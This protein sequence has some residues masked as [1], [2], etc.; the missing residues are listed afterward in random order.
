MK[1]KPGKLYLI[2]TPIGASPDFPLVCFNSSILHG[3]HVF[4]VEAEKSARKFLKQCA[5]PHPFEHQV[6]LELNEHTHDTEAGAFLSYVL[7]GRD[8][9][10]MSEAG[11]P[12]IA[13]PGAKAVR[14]A[15]THGIEVIPLPG[16]S[17]VFLALMASGGNGQQF[18]FHGYLPIAKHSRQ[19][20][21]RDIEHLAGKTGA[22][23]IF[24]ETP[25]R[26]ISLI[27]QILHTCRPDTMLCIACD[28][29]GPQQ[30]IITDTVAGWKVR[31]AGEF[32][33]IPAVFIMFR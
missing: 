14:L 33:K 24:M 18:T 13:D 1:Q 15:H 2:P 8:A 10:L 20:K 28:L 16:P 6:F 17:S 27:E 7:E 32:R 29:L 22:S 25:Y 12:C 9:G 21:L 5:Y 26:N 4:V 11:L 31:Q 19:V 23:Q 30:K 3:I